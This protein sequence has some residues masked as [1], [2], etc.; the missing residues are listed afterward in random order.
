MSELHVRRIKAFLLREYADLIDVSDLPTTSKD[1]IEA[2]LLTRGQAALSL[3][4]IANIAPNEACAAI[5]D[6]PDDN[7]ID[8]IHFNEDLSTLYIIQ[9]KWSESGKK[10]ITVGDIEKFVTGANDLLTAKFDRFNQKVQARRDEIE[11]AIDSTDVFITLV[12]SHTGTPPLSSH[13]ER[14]LNDLLD[15]NNDV[16]DVLSYRVY[17]Q[18]ALYT[19]ISGGLEGRPITLDI[20]VHDWGKVDEPFRAYYGRVSAAEIANWY[21]EHNSRLFARNLRKFKGDT[22]VNRQI[23]TTLI[24]EPEKFW[25]FNNGI[26]VLCNRIKKTPR[27]ASSRAAGHFHCEG[28]SVVNGA[29]TVGNIAATVKQGFPKAAQAYVLVRFISLEDCP[30]DFGSE[31]TTATNTQNRIEPID[32]ASLDPFQEQ[33]K[34]ELS[35]DMQKTYVYKSGDA[36]PPPEEGCTIEHAT[37]ALACANPN[38]QLA[39]QAKSAIGTLWEDIKKPPY[40]LVFNEK[41]S[42]ARLWH[43][44]EVL[45]AVDAVLEREKMTRGGIEKRIAIHGNRFI[46]HRVLQSLP[47]HLFD[48]PDLDMEPIKQQAIEETEKALEQAAAVVKLHFSDAYLNSFFKSGKKCALLYQ[49]LPPLPEPAST[50]YLELPSE[51]MQKGLF[52]T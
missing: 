30:P 13:A 35:L 6:G 32:F 34:Q 24:R 18:K 5:V 47:A 17:N 27:G 19:A 20:T 26:T 49:H 36:E 43:T 50:P 33:L 42:A 9:S 41:L 45:R 23:K 40:I 51:F 1:H 37:I 11:T 21:E 14:V 29:Q 52:D 10:S 38:I 3:A 44:V 4:H 8:A 46:L 28:I 31:V 39:A 7:G 22:E 25:Y 15:E 12:I 2:H 48:K 16:S